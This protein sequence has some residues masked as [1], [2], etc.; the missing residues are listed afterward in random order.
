MVRKSLVRM[1]LAFAVFGGLLGPALA[2]DPK[3]LTPTAIELKSE[4]CGDGWTR[5]DSIGNV[6]GAMTYR[7]R[8]TALAANDNDIWVGTSYDRLLNR[9]EDKWTLQGRLD[10]IQITGIA[11]ESASKVWLSTS[12]GIRRLEREADQPWRINEF[13]DYYEGHP[14]FVSGGYIPGEDAVRLWGYVDDW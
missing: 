2:E 3:T 11:V 13:R 10:G 5:W 7:E 1:A 14:S 4:P 8:I 9:H 12:D 6:E